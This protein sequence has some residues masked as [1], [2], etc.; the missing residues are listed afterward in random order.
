MY[1]LDTYTKYLNYDQDAISWKIFATVANTCFSKNLDLK[2]NDVEIK[3]VSEL[4]S[5]WEAMDCDNGGISSRYT[6]QGITT[7]TVACPTDVDILDDTDKLILSIRDNEVLVNDKGYRT[8]VIGDQKSVILPKDNKY[9]VIITG[10][11]VGTMNYSINEYSGSEKR[12][13]K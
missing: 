11:D 13:T 4:V 8:I 10:T 7:I 3:Y 6:P 12:R 9:H 2:K 5:N 1:S